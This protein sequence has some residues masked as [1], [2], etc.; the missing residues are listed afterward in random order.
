MS[1]LQFTELTLKTKSITRPRTRRYVS[2]SNE[3]S[4]SMKND[5]KGGELPPRQR[6][7]VY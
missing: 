1:G 7:G 3:K 4:S 5:M 6:Q 2:H